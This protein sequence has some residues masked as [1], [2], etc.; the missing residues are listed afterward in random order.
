[1]LNVQLCL[2]LRPLANLILL[3]V[4]DSEDSQWIMSWPSR[5]WQCG[6]A[7]LHWPPWLLVQC[8]G[9]HCVCSALAEASCIKLHAKAR[10]KHDRLSIAWQLISRQAAFPAMMVF[11]VAS[12]TILY[13]AMVDIIQNERSTSQSYWSSM[14]RGVCPLQWRDGIGSYRIISEVLLSSSSFSFAFSKV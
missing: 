9:H 5:V 2:A 8:W 13:C 12:D 7:T 10:K 14:P 3:I 11:D 6:F 4:C 1:M